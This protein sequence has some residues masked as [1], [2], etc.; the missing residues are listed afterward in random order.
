MLFPKDE[1]DAYLTHLPQYKIVICR[2]CRFAVPP[3]AIKSHLRAQHSPI[4]SQSIKGIQS[5]IDNLGDSVARSAQDVIYPDPDA[6]PIE[7]LRTYHD[8]L[9]CTSLD[10]AGQQCGYICR[11]VARMQQHSKSVHKW[12]NLSRRLPASKRCDGQ[13]G[14][15]S[16]VRVAIATSQLQKAATNAASA[17]AAWVTLT[18]SREL[19][20]RGSA[21]EWLCSLCRF[22][23]CSSS[24]YVLSLNLPVGFTA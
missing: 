8:G 18:G 13:G 4:S 1:F 5:I 10:S 14:L 12:V 22:C 17:P 9:R 2:S 15:R 3:Q 11:S 23:V 20:N 7:R 16:V 19:Q 24:S 6:E 21:R